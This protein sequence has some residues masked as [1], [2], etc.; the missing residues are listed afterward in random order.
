MRKFSTPPGAV[1]ISA[2]LFL[3]LL[4]TSNACRKIDRQDQRTPAGQQ[5]NRFFNDHAPVDPLVNAIKSCLQRSN[6]KTGF[7]KTAVERA[8]YPRWNKAFTVSPAQ[9]RR[10]NNEDSMQITYIPFVKD[11]QNYVNAA[12]LVKTT[13]TDTAIQWLMD[14]QY[15][16]YGFD[17]TSTKWSAQ[18]VFHI[19]AVLDK[20]VFDRT[21]FEIIDDSL[22]GAPPSGKIVLVKMKEGSQSQRSNLLTPVTMCSLVDVCTG[23]AWEEWC[24]GGC[25]EGCE[26][27]THTE[28]IC[29]TFWVDDGWVPVSGGSGNGGG[30][31]GGGGSGGGGGG[32]DT[33]PGCP[34]GSGR[35]N[36]TDDPCGPGWVPVGDEPNAN[37]I[38]IDSLQGFPCAQEILNQLPS[39]NAETD[40]I[41]KQVFG[42]NDKVNIIFKTDSTLPI[43]TNG[44]T[45]FDNTT[46][47]A[48]GTINFY[49]RLNTYLLRNSA[50]EL[51]AKTMIHEAV[52]AYIGYYWSQY[53]QGAI[54][55]LEF[56][57]R[58]PLV[59]Q[60]KNKGQ[61]QHQQMA[62]NYLN[63]IKN[64]TLGYNPAIFD[65]VNTALAW[66]G[67]TWT[68][69]WTVLGDD[70]TRM[71]EI[72]QAAK[73]GSSTQMQ[74]L[75]L[76]K[77]N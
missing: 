66:N 26:Y 65:S 33:P 58:F 31:T 76:N 23:P 68:Q 4:I 67:L 51:I 37:Q 56:K 45:S 63:T 28:S 16:S 75:G 38:I 40:S 74:S 36:L 22:F 77:C 50:K 13:T 29:T 44:V 72:Y 14:W 46:F 20:E 49:I 52:H 42:V 18:D 17:S 8:G 1:I 2:C 34:T 15:A 12:L 48:N 27:Y 62:I 57:T 71:L 73:Y 54:D 64:F 70:T 6:E 61:A 7:V 55:S 69:P 39:C 53:L 32:E 24:N 41:L 21:E 19:F 5:E 11:S 3:L 59:W 10:G 35:N 25:T 30:G 60:Y 9:I 43:G 47:Q